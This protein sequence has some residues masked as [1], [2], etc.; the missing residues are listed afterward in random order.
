[1][2]NSRSVLFA[3]AFLLVSTFGFANPNDSTP[4]T[5]TYTGDLETKTFLPSRDDTRA[6]IKM[7]MNVEFLF[8]GNVFIYQGKDAKAM[9][10]YE[11]VDDKIIFTV[12]TVKGNKAVVDAIFNQDYSYSRSGDNLM[13]IGKST[14]NSDILVY[15]LNKQAE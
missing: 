5:G 4:V 2:K 3:M 6:S 7:E 12:N 11:L 15:K 1:M 13:L 14:E 9:G 8:N 10:N